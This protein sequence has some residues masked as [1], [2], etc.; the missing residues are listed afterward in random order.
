MWVP[1]FLEFKD[2]EV[3][4]VRRGPPWASYLVIEGTE[5][6]DKGECCDR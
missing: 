4:V 5:A 1:S 3:R 2:G 6:S